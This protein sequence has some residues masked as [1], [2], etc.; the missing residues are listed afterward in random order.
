MS[1]R[2]ARRNSRGQ[3]L[4]IFALAAVT[5][6]A[7][8]G[9]GVDGAVSYADSSLLERAAA[10]SS[11]AGVP[12]MPNGWNAGTVGTEVNAVAT[13]NGLPPGGTHNVTVMPSQVCSGGTCANN[14]LRVTICENVDTSFLGLVGFHRHQ[15]C[16]AATSEYLRPITL[17][18]PGSQLG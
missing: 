6:I 2:L 13:K 18:Q 15:E 10:A 4:V 3:T 1:R 17:G 16:Q 8:V 11:L 7:V 9:L 12:Y 14:K 5:I